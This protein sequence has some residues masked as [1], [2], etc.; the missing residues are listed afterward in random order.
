MNI[1]R[2]VKAFIPKKLFK[3][4]EP[5]GHLA[6]AILINAINGFPMR[7]LKVIGVTGTNGKTSTSSMIHAMMVNSGIDTGLMTTVAYGVNHDITSQVAHVTSLS[8]PQLL[9]RVKSM[10]KQGMEWLVLETTSH[11]LA[12]HQCLGSS[13]LCRCLTNVTHEHLDYHGTLNA[14]VTQN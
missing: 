2:A 13:I 7:G 9:D 12:Q 1:R 10:K 4:I 3:K 14:I 11:G 6:E 8:V 5:I